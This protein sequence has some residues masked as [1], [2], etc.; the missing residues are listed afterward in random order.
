LVLNISLLTPTPVSFTKQ[1]LRDGTVTFLAT[2]SKPSGQP[3]SVSSVAAGN[4]VV[5]Q[6]S[7][8]GVIINP[9]LYGSR[10]PISIQGLTLAKMTS[11]GSPGNPNTTSFTIIGAT[12]TAIEPPI[13]T[14]YDGPG[15][16]T[17]TVSFHYQYT[18]PD[19]PSGPSAY[20]GVLNADPITFQVIQ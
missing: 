5:D 20:R 9:D 14:L 11:L 10:P 1:M 12:A 19:P 13:D 15:P 7:V 16:G 4:I 2:I 18:G 8:D 3:V 6:V 17:Y